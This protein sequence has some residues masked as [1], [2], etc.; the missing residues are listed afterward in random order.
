MLTDTSNYRNPNYHRPS[1]TISTLDLVRFTLVV[2]GVAGAAY[3]IAEPD[4]TV[5][6]PASSTPSVPAPPK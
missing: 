4:P 6:P 2:R 1:D 3:A 5:N